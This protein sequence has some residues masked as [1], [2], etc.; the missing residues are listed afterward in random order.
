MKEIPIDEVKRIRHETP[1]WSATLNRYHGPSIKLDHSNI[2][3]AEVSPFI[4]NQVVKGKRK[5]IGNHALAVIYKDGEKYR[6][7]EVPVS[8][9]NPTPIEQSL[10]GG[11]KLVTSA[12]SLD[13][14]KFKNGIHLSQA[15]VTD[16]KKTASGMHTEGES[17]PA[18]QAEKIR[19]KVLIE[20]LAEPLRL[21]TFTIHPIK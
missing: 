12:T 19:L 5:Y 18:T 3:Q 15:T 8:V 6:V 9:Q 20:R 17:R 21:G 14:I 1:K 11:R 10:G 7:Y 2:I 4:T 16:A 13:H